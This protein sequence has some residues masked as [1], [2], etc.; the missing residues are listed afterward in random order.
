MTDATTAPAYLAISAALASGGT[1]SLG[2]LNDLF[3][4][5]WPAASLAAEQIIR[6]TVEPQ[7]AA[8]L[9]GPLK[10][11]K[12]TKLVLGATPPT[13][14]NIDVHA[15]RAGFLRLSLDVAWDGEADIELEADLL[16]ALGVRRL[17]LRGR[18]SVTLGPIVDR[19]PVVTAAKIAFIN[20]P[21]LE[22]DF[23][24]LA[25]V[26][27]WSFVD[28]AVRGIINDVLKGLLVLPQQL[29]VK[30]DAQTSIVE[31]H[32]EPLG[33][34]RIAPLRAG[35]FKV[36]NKDSFLWEDVP[37]VYLKITLGAHPT[38]RTKTV[39]DSTTPKFDE[40]RDFLLS[41]HDQL[42][43]VEAYDDDV[44]G[45]TYL[46]TGTLTVGQLLSSPDHTVE[47]VLRNAKKDEGDHFVDNCTVTL[48]CAVFPLGTDVASL[49]QGQHLAGL[50][51]VLV[52]NAYAVPGER[53]DMASCVRVT[54]GEREFCTP[55]V[56]DVPGVTDGAN[57]AFDKSFLVALGAEDEESIVDTPLVLTLEN[58]EEE[59]G[60]V[61]V[62][63][64]QLL[65]APNLTI[66][67]KAD[68]GQG[69]S[70]K[71]SVSLRGVSY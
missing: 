61:S 29:L 12:F 30:L 49:E 8:L 71:F 40:S 35:E 17:T 56:C 32:Q 36:Q 34:C 46:G 53:Q 6:E 24:G 69:A 1:E 43:T 28:K 22:L 48:R 31:A 45:D 14:D 42:V 7:F 18:V 25:D 70:I 33:V 19:L 10:S 55:I 66:E 21:A 64:A 50:L 15:R 23:T 54:F 11:L 52:A 58:G 2:W 63:Y 4:Q 38:W 20:P 44:T 68:V 41:D 57:P 27:D 62:K 37:D 65:E 3:A 13:F 47:V 26:A 39:D 60:Q 16:P 59:I 5:I 9:P 67:R 51:T